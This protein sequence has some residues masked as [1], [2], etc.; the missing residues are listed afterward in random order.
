MVGGRPSRASLREVKREHRR[1]R[2]ARHLALVPPPDP[3]R[4]PGR[5]LKPL[6]VAILLVTAIVAYVGLPPEPPSHRDKSTQYFTV[7]PAR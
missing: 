6:L 2:R 1:R 3:R 7:E 5:I 4:R